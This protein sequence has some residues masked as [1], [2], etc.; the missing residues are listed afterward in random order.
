MISATLVM[1]R[2]FTIVGWICNTVKNFNLGLKSP[3]LLLLD[4]APNLG[5]LTYL[6]WKSTSS[7]IAVTL[8]KRNYRLTY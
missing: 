2:T 4:S 1:Y 3:D 8:T 5:Q 6:V 7:K